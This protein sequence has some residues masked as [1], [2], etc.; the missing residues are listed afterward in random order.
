MRKLIV[1]F[2]ACCSFSFYPALVLAYYVYEGIFYSPQKH[3]HEMTTRAKH[4]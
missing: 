3:W 2:L 1:V 4:E